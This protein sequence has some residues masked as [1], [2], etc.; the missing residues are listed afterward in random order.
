MLGSCQ[1]NFSGGEPSSLS[2]VTGTTWLAGR[3]AGMNEDRLGSNTGQNAT[4]KYYPYGEDRSPNGL[5]EYKFATTIGRLGRIW[6]MR[7]SGGIRAGWGG[8][9]RIRM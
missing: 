1:L 8:C 2:M 5:S 9:R 7:I 4:A 6:I 3:K